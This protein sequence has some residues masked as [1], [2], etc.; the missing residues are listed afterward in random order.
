MENGKT[1]ASSDELEVVEM[2]RV[3]ARVRIDLECVV[4]VSGVLEEAVEGI[5]LISQRVSTPSQ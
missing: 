3:D 5:E 2:L 1:Q 4:I